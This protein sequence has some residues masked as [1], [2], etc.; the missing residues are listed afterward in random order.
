M[1]EDQSE[2]PFTC[3]SIQNEPLTL[4]MN[5]AGRERRNSVSSF[6]SYY[7]HRSSRASVPNITLHYRQASLGFP[8][9]GST[10]PTKSIGSSLQSSQSL[11]SRFKLYQYIKGA[12]QNEHQHIHKLDDTFD[13]IRS[14]LVSLLL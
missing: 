12:E 4:L 9:N 7:P 5:G 10:S 3:G 14:Q 13:Q 8:A 2:P 11:K 6:N 1:D